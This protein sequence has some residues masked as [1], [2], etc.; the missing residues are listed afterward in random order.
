MSPATE[1]CLSVFS[2]FLCSM[3]LNVNMHLLWYIM[4]LSIRLYHFHKFCECCRIHCCSKVDTHTHTGTP[5][6]I[7]LIWGYLFAN[8][9]KM[10]TGICLGDVQTIQNKQYAT[11]TSLIKNNYQQFNQMYISVLWSRT[12]TVSDAQNS[13]STHTHKHAYPQP[14]THLHNTYAIK[15]AIICRY[16]Q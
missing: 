5:N 2:V 1:F 11:A 14:P 4:H 9:I 3:L 7:A 10:C 6:S 8:N 12:N 16:T 13:T 15:L